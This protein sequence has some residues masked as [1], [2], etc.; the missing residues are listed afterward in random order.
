MKYDQEMHKE[1]EA[2]NDMLVAL[3]A[4]VKE[5]H[6]VYGDLN[7]HSAYYCDTTDLDLFADDLDGYQAD[8]VGPIL[9]QVRDAFEVEHLE[10]DTME[11][12]ESAMLHYYQTGKQ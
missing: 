6:T 10:A 11:S 5:F 4:R 9:E 7:T 1:I 2:I 3:H 12:D 8:E